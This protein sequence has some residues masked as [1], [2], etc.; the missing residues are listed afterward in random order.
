MSKLHAKKKKK[1]V[2]NHFLKEIVKLLMIYSLTS[3]VKTFSEQAFTLTQM[4]SNLR[5]D[6]CDDAGE[7]DSQSLPCVIIHSELNSI[8]FHSLVN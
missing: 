4:F 2:S 8:S 3:W 1:K 7:L 5:L 6:S